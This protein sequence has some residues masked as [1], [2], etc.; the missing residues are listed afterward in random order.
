MIW[1]ICCIFVKEKK[2]IYYIGLIIY[3]L[4]NRDFVK[5]CCG[6]MVLGLLKINLLR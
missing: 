5:W 2:G 3:G 1:Y 6:V 4:I